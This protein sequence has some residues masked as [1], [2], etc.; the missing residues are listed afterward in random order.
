MARSAVASITRRRLLGLMAATGAML[1]LAF[2]L[3]AAPGAEAA[4]AAAAAAKGG[5]SGW[6]KVSKHSNRMD[7]LGV[8]PPG[9]RCLSGSTPSHCPF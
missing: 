2:V 8:C 4:A 5:K 7:G 1:L 6:Q 3:A 9:R